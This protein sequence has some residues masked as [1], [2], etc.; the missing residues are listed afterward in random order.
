MLKWTRSAQRKNKISSA[1]PPEKEE[2]FS[3]LHNVEENL[4]L[5]KVELTNEMK[6]LKIQLV[7]KDNRIRHEIAKIDLLKDLQQMIENIINKKKAEFYGK[8]LEDLRDPL[9]YAKHLSKG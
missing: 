4:I 6:E 8:K 7:E 1:L 3:A 9:Y 5:E 2:K